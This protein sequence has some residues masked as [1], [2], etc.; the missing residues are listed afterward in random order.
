[1]KFEILIPLIH[2]FLLIQAYGT[3]SEMKADEIEKALTTSSGSQDPDLL[4]EELNSPSGPQLIEKCLQKH[5]LKQHLYYLLPEIKDDVIRNALVITC[6]RDDEFFDKVHSTWPDLETSMANTLGER[7]LGFFPSLDA[8]GRDGQAIVY[9][10]LTSQGRNSMANIYEEYFALPPEQRG[11]NNPAVEK[12]TSRIRAALARF[13]TKDFV[14]PPDKKLMEA[15]AKKASSDSGSPEF[16]T[17]KAIAKRPSVV[18]TETSARSMG[19]RPFWISAPIAGVLV[20]WWLLRKKSRM[21]PRK[22]NDS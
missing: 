9:T 19:L 14:N 3:F 5:T 1:M 6:L 2:I 22:K 21:M 7:L 4:L 18:E 11:E 20:L 10:L 13:G 15:L 12:V 17:P 8:K 16:S